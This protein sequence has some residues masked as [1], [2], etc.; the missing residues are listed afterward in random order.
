MQTPFDILANAYSFTIGDRLL[1][2]I[3]AYGVGTIAVV[4]PDEEGALA[5]LDAISNKMYEQYNR[6][7][8]IIP[9]GDPFK[10][11]RRAAGE[12]LAGIESADHELFPYRFMFM[13]R[14]EE[15]GSTFPTVLTSMINHKW[16]SCLTRTGIKNLDH[17]DLLHWNRY[18][19][20]DPVNGKW[21]QN[22]P[23]RDLKQ[24]EPLY[25]LRSDSLVVLI[26][27]VP[28][29]GD[30]NSPEGSFAFFTSAERAN[31][32]HQNHLGNG[33]NRLLPF[34]SGAPADTIEAMA[35]LS[36]RRVYDL[37]IRLHQLTK[38]N[39]QAAWCVNPN[40][41]RENSAYGRLKLFNL[42]HRSARTSAER[43]FET[44]QMFTVS[45]IWKILPNNLFELEEPLTHWSGHDTIGWSGG[46]SIQLLPL[47]RSFVLENGLEE[48][49]SA[50]DLTESEIEELVA[51]HIDSMQ[52]EDSKK[53]FIDAPFDELHSLERFYVVCWDAVTGE[54]ADKPWCFPSLYAAI[55][56]LAAYEREID[57]NSRIQGAGSDTHIGFAGSKNSAFEDLR[58]T[59][60]KLGLKRLVQRMIH[61]K[62]YRPSDA[63]DL[64]ALCNG[65]LLTLHVDYAG[66]A[67][68]LLWTTQED[69]RDK[70]LKT[71][72]I[73]E[74]H[75]ETWS[76]N[77][78]LSVDQRGE[79]LVLE[80]MDTK[81]WQHLE[82]KSR[83][84]LS[85]ALHH[86]AEQGSAPQLDYAP[87]SIEVV[88]GLEVEM[89][90]L[91]ADFRRKNSTMSFQYEKKYIA[92]NTLAKF[93][94]G[95]KP[96]TL[97]NMPFLLTSP[98]SRA[99]QLRIA[100]HAYISSLPNRDFLTDSNFVNKDLRRV[101]NIFRNGGAHD[102]PISE[103]TCRECIETL[104]G[105]KELPGL[106]PQVAMWKL[107]NTKRS[108]V[109]S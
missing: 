47:D 78:V 100:L 35:S 5:L 90:A 49:E 84:F 55:R 85:T 104:I 102:S 18:D 87:I 14:V 56:H 69:D 52:L 62:G 94:S 19:I 27:H 88:K 70:L 98:S 89:G 80:R 106:I 82:P 40:D 7:P 61:R 77:A 76:N 22:K 105:S 97:G 13:V 60:F 73:S 54:G 33:R 66:Y 28:L 65:I 12:G 51:H 59:R 42:G 108:E 57:R 92:E 45:G 36:P 21:G 53:Q 68:D 83:H 99:S 81:V 67:K 79:R 48:F 31:D 91:L 26:S 58:S 50:E 34:A 2:G 17:A 24:N 96:P 9:V 75:W 41:H 38:I 86:L 72:R 46:Q 107:D 4:M 8:N 74:K 10:F 43:I 11:M 25:E 23:L 44:L 16:S 6:K 1:P 101:V 109:K 93:L 71:F 103:S 63:A 95:H 29:L 30:W 64:V 15:A 3:G 20:L 37:R 39:L 32:Y